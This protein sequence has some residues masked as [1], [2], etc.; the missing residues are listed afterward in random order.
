M[1]S[2]FSVACLPARPTRVGWQPDSFGDGC[3]KPGSRQGE[4]RRRS[5]GRG[6]LVAGVGLSGDVVG[7][8]D[9]GGSAVRVVNQ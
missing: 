6:D 4:T 9:G 1:A 5:L 7:N 3:L 2:W 8:G